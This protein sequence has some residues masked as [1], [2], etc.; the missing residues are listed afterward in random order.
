MLANDITL[1]NKDGTDVVYRLTSQTSDGTRRLDVATTLAL[2]GQLSIKH[3]VT[4]KAPN[5]VDRHLVQLSRTVAASLGVATVNANFTLTVPRDVAVT[6]VV[7]YNVV[8]NIL[9]FLSDGALTGMA[10]VANVDALLRG[11][12]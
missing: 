5:I 9:D 11:E 10:T 4:G 6:N 12:S 2:P 7:V 8:S 1:D 3:S